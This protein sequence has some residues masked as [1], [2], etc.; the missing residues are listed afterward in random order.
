[1]TSQRY[2][3]QLFKFVTQKTQKFADKTSTLL[4]HT[5]LAAIW[6]TQILLYPIYALFQG[7][8]Y[9]GQQIGQ[10]VEKAVLRLRMSREEIAIDPETNLS[11]APIQNVLTAVK[12][13]LVTGGNLPVLKDRHPL[14][15]IGRSIWR[16]EEG[17]PVS[18]PYRISAIACAINTQKIVIVLED[19]VIF[20]ILNPEQQRQI[21]QRIRVE[22]ARY[23]QWRRKLYLKSAPLTLPEDREVLLPPIR[24][25]RQLMAWMQTSPVAIAA[26]LF[27]E[28]EL[29]EVAE[30]N[31]FIPSVPL[32]A[33]NPSGLIP[34]PPSRQ[35]VTAWFAQMPNLADL[36]ALIW[37]AIHYFFGSKA[38]LAT[39][40]ATL[41]ETTG[42]PWLSFTDVFG[43]TLPSQSVSE[44]QILEGSATFN[45]VL[46][47]T[48]SPSFTEALLDRIQRQLRKFP[49]KIVAQPKPNRRAALSIRTET[50]ITQVSIDP[51]QPL[52]FGT[53][54]EITTTQQASG[55]AAKRHEQTSV[56]PAFD[57]IETPA[58][59]VEY[60]H[61]RWQKI[62]KWFDNL[63]LWIER[64]IIALWHRLSGRN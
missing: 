54:T 50:R 27:Q 47:P 34:T 28:S 14:V 45:T 29:V 24:V 25:F 18:N 3:S 61:S 26:N 56:E 31:W 42:E 49:G 44:I 43:G 5:K 38:R 12:R 57:W 20:D 41:P 53:P 2:Q 51:V 9:I 55:M 52:D 23:W 21:E 22:L 17:F 36:E 62:L 46:L 58:T 32:A 64:R 30:L 19:N 33:W 40:G 37:A 10:R 63:I 8:R 48:Q 4:R 11:D 7:S 15:I 39:A 35:E 16:R 60:V 59:H 6:G 1:M 13:A